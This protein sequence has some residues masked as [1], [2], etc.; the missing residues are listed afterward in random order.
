MK[1]YKVKVIRFGSTGLSFP[2]EEEIEAALNGLHEEGYRVD[3]TPIARRGLLFIGTAQEPHPLTGLISAVLP[4]DPEAAP[5][6]SDPMATLK[7]R[8]VFSKLLSEFERES[9][10][11]PVEAAADAAVQIMLKN[12]D[13][14]TARGVADFVQNQADTHAKD[15]P[16]DAPCD[17]VKRLK[18]LHTAIVKAINTNVS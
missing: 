15:H 12:I 1:K 2:K 16:P 14:E 6:S 11:K 3:M 18:T 9:D 8:I 10:A 13:L 17:L 7:M 5:G 4:R